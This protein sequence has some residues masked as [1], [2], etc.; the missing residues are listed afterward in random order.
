MAEFKRKKGES[1][2]GF[3]RR[4]NRGLKNSKTLSVAR[5]KRSYVRGSNKIRQKKYA[6][7]SIELRKE[8]DYLRKTGK[9]SESSSSR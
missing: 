9:I 6:L 8:K 4:F 7:K 2:E 1:F 5:S 3:L